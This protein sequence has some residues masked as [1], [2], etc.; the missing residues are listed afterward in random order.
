MVVEWRLLALIK[1]KATKSIMSITE[2][3]ANEL[4]MSLHS[5]GSRRGLNREMGGLRVKEVTDTQQMSMAVVANQRQSL[6]KLAGKSFRKRQS[7]IQT[8][9]PRDSL[10]G[11]D[12]ET[13]HTVCQQVSDLLSGHTSAT[14]PCS[15]E[16]SGI[17]FFNGE[18]S[19]AEFGDATYVRR[20]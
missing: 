4:E 10:D 7:G 19:F 1:H 9:S 12:E 16:E 17:S 8:F 15:L 14:V 18:E 3:M 2:K 5:T 11:L 13:L 20:I 6:A